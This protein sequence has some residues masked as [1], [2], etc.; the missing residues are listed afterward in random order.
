[1]L[2]TQ[3]CD[4]S[5]DMLQIACKMRDVSSKAQQIARKSERFWLQNAANSTQIRDFSPKMLQVAR[6]TAPDWKT[7]KNP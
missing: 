2:A 1:M 7:K 3:I 5:S 6:K 4:F